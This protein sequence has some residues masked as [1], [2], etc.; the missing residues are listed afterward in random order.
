[1]L[2]MPKLSVLRLSH[3]LSDIDGFR[4]S[5]S[6]R[7]LQIAYEA[8]TLA[9][10]GL[11]TETREL[12]LGDASEADIDALATVLDDI[13]SL[14]LCGALEAEAFLK[15]ARRWRSTLIRLRLDCSG[16]L[17][18]DNKARWPTLTDLDLRCQ[19]KGGWHAV[20][21]KVQR[22][23]LVNPRPDVLDGVSGLLSLRIQA[24]RW[25]ETPLTR[26][27]GTSQLEILTFLSVDASSVPS[28]LAELLTGATA[29]RQLTLENVDLDERVAS[30]LGRATQ[31]EMLAL[32][33]SEF[34][35]AVLSDALANS[36]KLRDVSFVAC[37]IGAVQLTAPLES[38][39]LNRS[40]FEDGWLSRTLHMISGSSLRRLELSGCELYDFAPI[41]TLF[42]MLTA[43]NIGE[44]RCL[45]LQMLDG[46][47]RSLQM[48]DATGLTDMEQDD[49]EAFAITFSQWVASR[50]W[51]EL[52]RI[53]ARPHLAFDH[54]GAWL[55][56][57]AAPKLNILEGIV[58]DATVVCDYILDEDAQRLGYCRIGPFDRDKL[59]VCTQSAWPDVR[60][61]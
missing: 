21:P 32:S 51:P 30:A 1:M 11:F 22:M 8:G 42:P 47:E 61:F 27:R 44:V 36:K 13:E 6:P 52:R 57:R 24:N 38:L 54:L 60:P 43:L 26:W 5:T 15:F 12:E 50:S 40:Y 48:F 34:P 53:C 10:T 18:F 7:T 25:T 23:S 9:R 29:L 20:L 59:S 35:G 3:P 49:A 41:G 58:E 17:I 39:V 2:A 16:E 19:L 4:F 33:N 14:N 28:S 45:K 46:I 55:S 37:D 56:R 31:L